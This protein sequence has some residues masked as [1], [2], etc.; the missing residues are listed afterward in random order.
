MRR[1]VMDKG[2]GTEVA[3]NSNATIRVHK[4]CLGLE[5]LG[6]LYLIQNTTF[7]MGES[8]SGLLS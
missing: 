2:R 8:A 7:G 4:N 5:S 1:F 3:E 6:A